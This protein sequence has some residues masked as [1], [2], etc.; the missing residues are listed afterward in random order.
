M[1]EI[2]K[3]PAFYYV[4]AP[5]LVTIWPLLVWAVYLPRAEDNWRDEKDQYKKA[6][7]IITDILNIDPERLDYADSKAGAAEFDYAVAIEKVATECKIPPTSYK[8]SSGTIT[9][10]RGQKS[11]SAKVVLAQVDMVKFA[12]FLSTI[13]L[14]WANL[15]CGQVKLTKKKSPADS[16][17][18]DLDFKYYY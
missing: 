6:Q 18:V 8:L 16:W 9:T 17:N 7:V 15:Q 5:I 11:Q 14:R 12:Q 13:Q 3:N 1:K 10:S 4:L 2:Y